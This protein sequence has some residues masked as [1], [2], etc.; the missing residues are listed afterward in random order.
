MA[1][2][3]GSI[4]IGGVYHLIS[5]FVAKEWFIE[6]DTERRMYLSLLGTALRSTDWT[7]F[8]F[9]IMSSHIHLGLVA[10]TSRLVSWLRPMHTVFANWLNLQRERIGAV[11][12][13]GPNLIA[14]QPNECARL[15]NYIHYNPV[16]AGV[17]TAP[18]ESTWTS[19]RAYVGASR[20][21][22]WLSVEAGLA[23][24]GFESSAE[25]AEWSAATQ[26]DRE[27]LVAVRAL[28][29]TGRGRPRVVGLP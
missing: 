9:A 16:R 11:F 10:G 26:V 13:K 17:V 28:P 4:Q 6:S 7:C 20:A 8:S 14:V 25:Y 2:G 1:R 24:G 23:L 29:K 22:S 3:G 27:S 12:V 18:S 5:R 19:H 21:P 15:I